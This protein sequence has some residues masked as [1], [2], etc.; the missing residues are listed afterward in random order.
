MKILVH[1]LS[2]NKAFRGRRF[3]TP[4]YEAYEK[5]VFYQLKPMAI[6]KKA[7]LCVRIAV[8]FK[9]RNA[10]I[11]N[12]CKPLIDILQKKYHF[13]DN[14]IYRLLLCNYFFDM[15][16]SS[17]GVAMAFKLIIFTATSK[18]TVI[19]FFNGMFYISALA[20]DFVGYHIKL[21][22]IFLKF[23]FAYWVDFRG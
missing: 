4:E 11:D 14:Q 2:I 13:N 18:T 15:G 3:K 16:T 22:R 8:G 20:F 9:N 5:E 17:Y 21:N 10:D 23:N 12:I 19:K 7:K 1:P 6:S